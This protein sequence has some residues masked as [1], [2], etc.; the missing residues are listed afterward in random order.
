MIYKKSTIAI[1]RDLIAAMDF[2]MQITAVL[3]TTITTDDG[4]ITVQRLTVCNIM[5][6]EPGRDIVV[7]EGTYQIR[8]IDAD[9]KYIYVFGSIAIAPQYFTLY[10]PVFYYGT[11]IRTGIEL[12]QEQTA[13]NKTPM[14]WFAQLSTDNYDDVDSAFDRFINGDLFFLTQNNPEQWLTD[15]SQRLAVD[16]MRRLMEHFLADVQ[17][18][19]G[20]FYTDEFQYSAKEYQNFG[21]YISEKGVLQNKWADKLA[22]IKLNPCLT[23]INNYK[24]EVC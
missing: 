12:N 19:G 9:N 1:L 10:S 15:K 5:H 17:N 6:A 13:A 4:V 21:V 18:A 14:I 23:V 3:E 24:C 16:P 20:I 2:T 7:H 22:G 11:P 8:E